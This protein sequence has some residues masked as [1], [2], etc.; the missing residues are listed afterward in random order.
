MNP[1]HCYNSS[2]NDKDKFSL[3]THCM[4]NLTLVLL[5]VG[6]PGII[7]VQKY[8]FT[9]FQTKTQGNSYTKIFKKQN[10]APE[11]LFLN[12]EILDHMKN[13]GTVFAH[14]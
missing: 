9:C 13:L 12:I 14:L 1:L 2:D 10:S 6:G 4:T 11:T 8:T 7:T 5:R 3:I